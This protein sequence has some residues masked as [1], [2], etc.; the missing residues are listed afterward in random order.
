MIR[1]ALK[2]RLVSAPAQSSYSAGPGSPAYRQDRLA[3]LYETAKIRCHRTVRNVVSIIQ[4]NLG[5][6]FFQYD[7]ALVRDGCFFAGF[8][9][10][11]ESGSKQD[12]DICI[13]AL[14][15]MRWV[16]SKSEERIQTLRMVWESRVAQSRESSHSH[17]ASPTEDPQ[18]SLPSSSYPYPRRS[19]RHPNVTPL[20][21]FPVPPPSTVP[22]TSNSAPTTGYSEDGKWG[23][24]VADNTGEPSQRPS[25]S[26]QVQSNSPP[27]L[28]SRA[29]SGLDTLGNGYGEASNSALPHSPAYYMPPFYTDFGDSQISRDP[30]PSS[31]HSG[32]T[33]PPNLPAYQYLS[34]ATPYDTVSRLPSGSA[35]DS[36][37]E[38][39]ASS[40]YQGTNFF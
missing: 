11:G 8:L 29:S 26:P 23:S 15:E 19:P 34:S 31:S 2:Q 12:V 4:R 17:P 5:T 21:Y 6:S 36:H 30:Q 38:P 32:P 24:T 27:F 22:L 10:A 39:T 20:T 3:R 35:M 7:A 14:N 37:P 16:F 40:S 28:P 1:E 25:V 33:T 9:L 13:E 18:T